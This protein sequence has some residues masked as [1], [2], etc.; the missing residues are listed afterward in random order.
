MVI[1]VRRVI[2]ELWSASGSAAF[3]FSS[4]FSRTRASKPALVRRRKDSIFGQRLFGNERS[5][6][7]L[8]WNVQGI[9]HEAF[10]LRLFE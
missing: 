6:V 9:G 5:G 7:E 4:Q 2:S 3:R 1:A 10:A 8:D